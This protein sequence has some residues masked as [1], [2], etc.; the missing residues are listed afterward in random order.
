MVEARPAQAPALEDPAGFE[1]LSD[2]LVLRALLRA[3]FMT[4]GN[5]HAVCH[6]FQSLLKSDTFRKQRLEYGLAEHALVVAGGFREDDESAARW[7]GDEECESNCTATSDCRM[8]LNGRWRPIPPMSG[9]RSRFC[10][11]TI[12]DEMWVMGGMDEDENELASVEVM[13]GDRLYLDIGGASGL[14]S[15]LG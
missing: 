3:P 11:V 13:C 9:P 8:L 10:S 15:R 2:D 6:R 12:D 1:A 4:H 14:K 7:R 5:L